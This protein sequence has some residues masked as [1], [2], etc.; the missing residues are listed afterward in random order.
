MKHIVSIV[1]AVMVIAASP[2]HADCLDDAAAFHRVNPRL[3]RVIAQHESGMRPNAVNRNTNGSEDIGLM[4]INTSWLPT[5]SRYGIRRE[6]L[7]NS[8]VSAYVGA[9]ILASNVRRFG[10][11]WKAVGAY[12]AVTPSKQLVYASAIYRRFMQQGR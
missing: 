2:A 3:L 9:W 7:F 5:L 6:H 4:Q 10:P 1:A 11:N 12:N 8:C